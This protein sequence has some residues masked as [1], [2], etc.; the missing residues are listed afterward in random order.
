M[1]A[2]R[3]LGVRAVDN[4][5]RFPHFIGE[6]PDHFAGSLG[7]RVDGGQ[8]V[9]GCVGGHR[10]CFFRSCWKCFNSLIETCV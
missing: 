4:Q 8:F 10:C 6:L 3:T 1:K 2:A 7:R 5:V 9:R